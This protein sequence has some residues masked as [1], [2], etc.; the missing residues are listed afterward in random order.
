MGKRLDRHLR[1]RDHQMA[2][3]HELDGQ[4]RWLQFDPAVAPANL[5]LHSGL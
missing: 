4:W 3:S 1:D 5:K 2:F